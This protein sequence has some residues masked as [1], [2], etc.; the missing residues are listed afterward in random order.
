[1]VSK[2]TKKCYSF[3]GSTS[4]KEAFTEIAVTYTFFDI[5][6]LYHL[7]NIK[8]RINR[9][10][11]D[12]RHDGNSKFNVFSSTVGQGISL[13]AFRLGHSRFYKYV[14]D[15]ARELYSRKFKWI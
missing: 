3:W 2:N 5:D 8:P 9:I 13:M 11:I 7:N 6:L 12:Y 4:L 15:W 1:M 14:P 10:E